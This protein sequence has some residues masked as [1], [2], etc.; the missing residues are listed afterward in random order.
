MLSR[1]RSSTRIHR[2]AADVRA[3]ADVRSRVGCWPS[4]TRRH[5][6]LTPTL[7]RA[8]RCHPGALARPNPSIRV[9][10]HGWR[11][12][13]AIMKYQVCGSAWPCERVVVLAEHNY[14]LAAL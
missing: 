7:G 11:P 6:E 3:G 1:T 13:V 12:A 8:W 2:I 5:R 4:I 10:D 14:E 9:Q